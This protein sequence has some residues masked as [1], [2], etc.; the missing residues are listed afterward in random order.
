M[1]IFAFIFGRYNKHEVQNTTTRYENK[2][3]SKQKLT[4]TGCCTFYVPHRT[5]LLW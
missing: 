1:H 5:Q 2:H 3:K 4:S